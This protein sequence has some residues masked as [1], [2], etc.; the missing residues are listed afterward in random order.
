MDTILYYIYIPF[1]YLLEWSWKIVGNYGLAIIIFTLFTKIILLP[2][3]IW[4]Q[5]NSIL[6]VKIQPQINNLKANMYGNVDAIAEGQAE[7]FK[8]ERYHPMLSIIPLIIQVI[9]LLAVVY[10]IY[11]PLSYLY[12]FSE[13]EITALANHIGA[14]TESSNYQLLIIDSIKSGIINTSSSIE[15]ISSEALANIIAKVTSLDLN[16]CGLNLTLVAMETK[17]IYFIVPILAGLSS[18]VMCF[19]QN[20]ANV[21]QKEQGKL[22]QYGIMILSVALSLYLGMFV[23]SGIALYWIASN[24]MS[25]AQM[26]LLNMWINPKKYVDYQA[27][28]DS[29]IALEKAKSYGK[30]DKHTPLYKQMR[31]KEKQDYKKFKHIVGKHIVFYS[32]KSGFYKYYKDIIEELLKKSNITIHYVTNDYNDIIF[33]I[34]KNNPKIK[35]Y[36]IGLKKLVVLMMLVET[37]IFVMTTQDL[38]K[39]YLKRSFIKKDIEYIYVPHDAMSSHMGAREGAFDEYDTIFCVGP[40]FKNEV[41]KTEEIYKLKP[42]KLVEFGFPYLDELVNSASKIKNENHDVKEILI[43][44]SWQEDNLMDSCLDDIIENLLDEKYHITVRPHPEYSKRF[45]FKL[46]RIVEKYKD[47]D[48]KKLSFE[49]D[50]SSS[51]SIYSSDLLITDW[52]GVAAEFCFATKRPALYINTKMKVSN[53]NWQKIGITPMEIMLR[54]E[55]GMS[56]DKENI[57]DIKETINNLLQNSQKYKQKIIDYFDKIIYN[58]NVAAQVGADYIL[59]SLLEKRKK[60][61]TKEE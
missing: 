46:E 45:N 26:Y 3:S 44:P 38:N 37:D 40:H 19:T 53:P 31:K 8:K 29:R 9:L 58:H 52:S 59:K 12:H 7:L 30:I 35:P 32:E 6:M 41:L 49:L 50:F 11:R 56:I 39:F 25:V 34:A 60:Q 54:N 47:V 55:I 24:L 33:D 13:S 18:W 20:L 51:K 22:N 1:G 5:K 42:K 23:P 2:L 15:G 16:F 48:P 61:N 17:G 10:I 27:L 4:I 14:S 28:N 43:A 36:Y 57:K 21:I